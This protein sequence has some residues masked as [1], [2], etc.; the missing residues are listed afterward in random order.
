M[1]RPQ[2]HAVQRVGLVG[3]GVIG[4]GWA[5][6][7]LARGLD[8]TATDPH[9][10]GEARIRASVGNAWPALERLGLSPGA[11]M[12]RLKFAKDLAGAVGDADFIQESATENED[13]KT[14]LMAEIDAAAR[15]DVIIASSTSGLLPSRFQ[16]LAR[17]PD[18]ILVGH[19]FNPVYLLPLVEV[20]GGAATAEHAKDWAVAFYNSIGK[21]ALKCRREVAGFISDRLQEALW[22]EAL[23]LVNDG[24]GTTE[25]VDDAIRFGPGLRW[26]F[27]GSFLTYHLAGGDAGMAH[28]IEQFGPALELPWTNHKG[29]PM[30]RELADKLVAGTRA[31]AAGLSVKEIERKRDDVLLGIM[32]LLNERWYTKR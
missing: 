18:R 23:H 14:K 10:E 16:R 15:P 13:L 19:P 11:D 20:V 27:M 3:G 26:A 6:Y 5:A 21:R 12:R 8:V 29:P 7:F 1:P 9:P 30:T 4:S 28:F 22:R 31:Q 2:P 32:E 24:I 17:Q 25:E